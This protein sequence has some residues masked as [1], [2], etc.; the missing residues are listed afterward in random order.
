[1][2]RD[3]FVYSLY[4][5]EGDLLY[6]GCTNNLAR[7]WSQHQHERPGLAMST[8]RCRVVGPFKRDVAMRLERETQEDELPIMGWIPGRRTWPQH[9]YIE[10][11]YYRPGPVTGRQKRRA[12][13]ASE[14]LA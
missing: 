3:S 10:R 5:A 9:R 6:V 11:L 12:L 13:K 1:M 7:R 2:N 14:Q 4:D 8:V